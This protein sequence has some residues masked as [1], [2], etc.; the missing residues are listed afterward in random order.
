M[1]VI[2]R[3]LQHPGVRGGLVVRQRGMLLT[4]V[5][6]F[7]LLQEYSRYLAVSGLGA[8]YAYKL[9]EKG[10]VFQHGLIKFTSGCQQTSSSIFSA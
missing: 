2:S 1:A 8:D 6:R 9:K 5:P 10:H 4:C 7:C 3:M